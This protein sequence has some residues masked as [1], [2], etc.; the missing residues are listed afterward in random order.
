M[1]HVHARWISL[2]VLLLLYMIRVYLVGGFYIITYALGIYLLQRF[3]GF[4]SP[5]VRNPR[6]MTCCQWLTPPMICVTARP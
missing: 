2:G 5:K 3:I 6:S 4:L 1:P